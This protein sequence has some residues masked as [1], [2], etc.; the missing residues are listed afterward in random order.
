MGEKESELA[1]LYKDDVTSYVTLCMHA[2]GG[3]AEATGCTGGHNA[4]AAAGQS[5]GGTTGDAVRAL[6]LFAVATGGR[7]PRG[8]NTGR[9]RRVCGAH[10]GAAQRACWGPSSRLLQVPFRQYN[11]YILGPG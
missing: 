2:V 11:F 3:A 5:A 8:G 1:K 9:A 4:H 7:D 10:A 6:R